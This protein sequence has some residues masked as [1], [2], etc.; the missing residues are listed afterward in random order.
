MDK[1]LEKYYEG[2]FSMMVTS[3][4]SDLMDDLKQMKTVISDIHNI[5]D[6]TN[7]FFRKGQLDIINLLLT[8]QEAC[9]KSYEDLNNEENV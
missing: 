7:L 3:G 2:Q 4:W 1:A 9:S 8:R 6:E 5:P